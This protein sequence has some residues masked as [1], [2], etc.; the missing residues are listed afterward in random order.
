[1]GSRR[2]PAQG[3]SPRSIWIGAPLVPIICAVAKDF[4]PSLSAL[5]LELQSAS[6]ALLLTGSD[7]KIRFANRRF[8][9]MFVVPPDMLA[10]ADADEFLA[11]VMARAADPLAVKGG[12]RA[13]SADGKVHV[14]EWA[15]ADGRVIERSISPQ[16]R[17]GEWQ[18]L[19]R[20]RDVTD[21][22]Q[23]ERELSARLSQQAAVARLGQRALRD[24]P[25]QALLDESAQLVFETLRVEVCG[26][27][28]LEGS[29][30][31][32]VAGVG[33]DRALIGKLRTPRAALDELLARAGAQFYGDLADLSREE[34]LS[35]PPGPIGLAIRS[36]LRVAIGSRESPWGA[37]AAGVQG[38]RNFSADDG[39]FLEA[40]ANVLATA[41]ERSQ[42]L[43]TLR[44]TGAS[45]RT[46]IERLPDVVL[47]HDM[48][49]LRYVNPAAVAYYGFS[50]AD[51]L[52]GRSAYSL[53][54]PDE[55][56]LLRKRLAGMVETGRPAPIG[57]PRTIDRHGQVRTV[58]LR[59][60][61][62]LFEGKR[63]Y[64]L[65]GRDL[66]ERKQLEARLHLVDRMSSVGTLAAGVAHEL[67]NPLAWIVGNLDFA[68]EELGSPLESPNDL[69]AK[70]GEVV[71]SLR[72]AQV[73]ADR[74][75]I[76]VGDLKTFSRGDEERLGLVD[77]NSVLISSLNIAANE[78]R[79][80][81]RL[82]IDL[83]TIPLVEANEAR[84]GQVFLNLLVNAAQAIATGK[85]ADNE[86]S[87][88]TRQAPG[89]RIVVEVRDTG[90]GIP[91]EIAPR[92]FDPFFTT[93]PVGVGTGLGL[94]ICHNLVASFG[95]AIEVESEPGK[96]ALFRV[97]LPGVQASV[98]AA[99]TPAPRS[100]SAPPRAVR[101]LL[102]IDDEPLVVASIRRALR[103]D[104]HVDVV[105]SA[106]DALQRVRGGESFDAILCDLLMPEMTGMDLK[107][108]LDELA[109]DQARRMLFMTGG[110]FTDAAERFIEQPGI[111]T[112]LKPFS[113]EALD[114]ALQGLEAEAP[115]Q[116]LPVAPLFDSSDPGPGPDP[117]PGS[118]AKLSTFRVVQSYTT[119]SVGDASRT[120]LWYPHP[121][122][123]STY[124]D[125]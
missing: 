67:N 72:E 78:I 27:H 57:E 46:L 110:A 15:L 44:T 68:I 17:D 26:I 11:H 111:R 58:E 83:G 79:H 65:I 95:G 116:P 106:A 21:R 48:G 59:S 98:T 125:P 55:H 82:S 12:A 97:L 29:S 61:P 63:A 28:K 69:R 109:P 87:V 37:L 105:L 34:R 36:G 90:A 56:E 76:I 101:H 120:G 22:R 25:L 54:H 81:A 50:T 39:H 53:F 38:L 108:A 74:M 115:P 91:K 117:G 47:V 32:L 16:Q 71:Q 6:D 99:A 119:T 52:V 113:R 107:S 8:A 51:E 40:I 33:W 10:R 18:R 93:K 23:T 124:C 31:V 94:S 104:F 85:V 77:V 30:V 102:V 103:H 43:E 14:D 60:M 114:A 86:V 20:F 80:R 1:M 45:F 64:L 9:E 123:G 75:R 24:G 96:G 41:A 42:T 3:F 49:T 35:K 92:I 73:G 121:H 19:V 66:T 62:V 70:V 4:D 100:D 7:R 2:W 5:L 112:L 89:G 122:E 88:A 13:A 84:L 118:S